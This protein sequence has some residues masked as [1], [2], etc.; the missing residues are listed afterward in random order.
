MR[1]RI[2]RD[3]NHLPIMHA[4]RAMG[5]S[6]G[7]MAVVGSHF[8]DLI[9]ADHFKTVLIELKLPEGHFRIGQ[10]EFLSAWKGLCAFATDLAQCIAIMND[11]KQ[12]CLSQQDKN[13]MEG[14]AVRYRAKTKD[15][16]PRMNVTVFD[17]LMA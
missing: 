13:K 4:L 8:P 10:L 17:K 7:D 14:I 12:Y 3:K 2:T 1:R 11:P 15:N 16:D 6:V 5:Y 9:V